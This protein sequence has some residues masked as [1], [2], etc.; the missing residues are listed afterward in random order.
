MANRKV[1]KTKRNSTASTP[2]V[3]V[4][5]HDAADTGS[6]SAYARAKR[7][8]HDEY[9]SDYVDANGHPVYDYK[10][11]KDGEIRL[12]L[13]D[14]QLNALPPDIGMLTGLT[15]LNLRGCRLTALPPEIR[16]LKKLR[17][18]LLGGNRLSTL[19]VEI[20]QLTALQE[21]DLAHNQQACC[22][23]KSGS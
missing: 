15:A 20:G 1:W 17:T 6:A 9:V 23:R 7:R 21:L 19:P 14:S 12:D 3:A 10:V 2:K 5:E 13:S 8:I 16:K 18:L 22:R 4:H 11:I